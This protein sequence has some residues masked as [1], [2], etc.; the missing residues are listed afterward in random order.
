MNLYKSVVKK[1]LFKFNPETAHRIVF[2]LIKLPI[3]VPFLN[4]FYNFCKN[5][6]FHQVNNLK[7]K[8]RIG[9]AAGLDKDGEA[10][11]A[12]SGLGFGFLEIG[13]VTPKSQ[14]GNPKPR[15]F[16]LVKNDAL[17]NRMGFNNHGVDAL[18]KKLKRIKKHKTVIGINIGKNKTTQ[19]EDAHKD[20]A[21]CFE[22][23]FDYADYFA[24][25]VSSPNTKDLRKLQAVEFL[26]L[27]FA[28]IQ[29]INL[30]KINPKPVY[31]KIAPE[32][33]YEQIDDVI[34]LVYRFKLNGIIA[35]NTTISR[36]NLN[37]T[38]N[39][40]NSFGDGGLSGR[41]LKSRSTEVIK[42]I[43]SKTNNDLTIIGVGGVFDFSDFM[44]KIDAGA[45][46]VQIYTSFIYEGPGI[47]KRINKSYYNFLKNNTLIVN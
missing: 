5:E 39:E 24:I 42:Y 14:Q 6:L 20:Y 25:N 12:L 40:I 30:K 10:I 9:L 21:Y 22:H 8:N 7:F 31:V 13:T 38:E 44:E 29:T 11:N 18:I 32:L 3:M 17:I 35:T 28:E 41:P 33:T 47:V 36:K 43:K 46:L 34:N 27:I 26:E 2:N 37:Y 15:L 4:L 19:L 1:I 45:D 16:R 23:L